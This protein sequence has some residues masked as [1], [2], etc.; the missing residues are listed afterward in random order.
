MFRQYFSDV[1]VLGRVAV[2]LWCY[3]VMLCDV[4]V[5]VVWCFGD[6]HRRTF[7]VGSEAKKK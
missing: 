6:E 1:L 5:M 4:A 2:M 3:A 7:G